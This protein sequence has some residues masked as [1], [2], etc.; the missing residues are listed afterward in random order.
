MTQDQRPSHMDAPGLSDAAL[1]D[2]FAEA[3]SAAPEALVQGLDARLM[4]DAAKMLP[5]RAALR[6][7]AGIWTRFQSLLSE[8]GGLPGLRRWGR[9][10][11]RGSGLALPNPGAPAPC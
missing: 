11:L 4:S 1:E 8:L 5:L 10:G 6:P 9:R 2:L 3:R 7:Q